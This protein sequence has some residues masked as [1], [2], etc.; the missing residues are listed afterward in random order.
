[1]PKY[2]IERE[3]PGAGKLGSD[4][5]QAISKK[6]CDVLR[7]MTPEINWVQSYV[8]DDMI[9]CVYISPNEELLREHASK[10][11]FPITSIAKVGSIIDP[12]SGE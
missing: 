10:G 3:L 12:T 7:T 8:T 2:V 9:Y 4:E 6:S 5:L 11:E 1:M